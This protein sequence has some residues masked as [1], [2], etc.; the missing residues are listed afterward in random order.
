MKTGQE[1]KKIIKSFGLTQL[2]VAH[3]LDFTENKM[4]KIIRGE[5]IITDEIARGIEKSILKMVDPEALILK[6]EAEIE[7]KKQ[8]LETLKE[9]IN[10]FK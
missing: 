4:S 9:K 5:T 3:C 10:E 1:Y 7:Q 6:K 8:D 2:E